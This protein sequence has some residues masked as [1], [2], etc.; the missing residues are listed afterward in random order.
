MYFAVSRAI[1]LVAG[2]LTVMWLQ[3][4]W[5]GNSNPS[6][7]EECINEPVFEGRV[8]TLQADPDASTGVLL[9]HGLDGSIDDW[10][11][12]I[13]VLAKNFHVLAF[14]LPGFG[15]SDKG[16]QKYSPTRYAEL[17]RFL[18]D[19]YF[20]DKPYD[21][22]GHSMGGAIA[23][24]YA[25]QRP[26]RLKRLVLMDVAGILHPLVISKFQAGSMV[27]RASGISETRGLIEHISGRVLEQAERLPFA[28]TEIVNTAIGRDEIL[29]GGAAGIAALALAGE[30][31][32]YAISSVT[33]PTLIIWGDNDLTAPLRTGQVLAANMR[34][35]HLEIV[36]GSGH[37]PMNDQPDLTN[38]LILRHLLSS[39]QAISV[40]KRSTAPS[41]VSDMRTGICKGESG[42][43][44]EGNYHTI[45]LHDCSNVTIR[46]VHVDMLSVYDSRVDIGN[47]SI[48]G[49]ELGLYADNSEVTVTNG[50]ISGETA[51]TAVRSRLD[52]AGVHLKA[53]LASLRGI[54]SKLTC[55]VC[56]L[57]SPARQGYLHTFKKMADEE[58]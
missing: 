11:N 47:S 28:P 37:E 56:R 31:F 40:P 23:L 10:R 27:E 55:S 33:V 21:V 16:S 1:R 22:I 57:D 50:L 26:L 18:I 29:Q 20:R 44:F 8:C 13:P 24:R 43:I 5:C 30:D 36:A 15:K 42:M 14:D 41:E 9:I 52:L 7:L 34:D 32:S 49:K 6:P 53:T 25:A 39:D 4:A 58:L 45:E 3:S 19:H 51:I 54:G 35:A 17:V 2:L 38:G 48:T 46:D 12:T